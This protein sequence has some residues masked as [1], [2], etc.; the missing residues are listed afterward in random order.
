MKL[1]F[2]ILGVI[3]ISALSTEA[4]AEQWLFSPVDKKD[5]L[6]LKSDDHLSKSRLEALRLRSQKIMEQV[7]N[8]NAKEQRSLLL[9]H[10]KSGAWQKFEKWEERQNMLRWLKKASKEK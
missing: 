9:R 4:S 2:L 1:C 10:H 7:L 6:Y 3:L 8:I 5:L